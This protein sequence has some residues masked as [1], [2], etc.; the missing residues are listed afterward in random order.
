VPVDTVA[1][2]TAKGSVTQLETVAGVRAPATLPVPAQPRTMRQLAAQT[3]GIAFT[4]S[5]I[6]S[7]ADR[8]R[9]YESFHA[10]TT[11]SRRTENLGWIAAGIALAFMLAGAAVS[12]LEVGRLV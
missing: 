10:F 9:V 1:I 6:R 2:G 4:A 7:P 8:Q 12:G 3:S 5:S 11:S